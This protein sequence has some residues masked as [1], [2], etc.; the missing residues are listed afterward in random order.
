[1]HAVEQ[2]FKNAT[3]NRVRSKHA[4]KNH[5]KV[6]AA[7]STDDSYHRWDNSFTAF[8]KTLGVP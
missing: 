2:I 3:E 5:R 1:M 6:A 8:T 4:L 7:P